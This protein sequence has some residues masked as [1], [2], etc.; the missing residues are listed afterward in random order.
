METAAIVLIGAF[1]LIAVGF[2][3]VAFGTVSAD[4][5]YRMDALEAMK[6]LANQFNGT[7]SQI[8]EVHNGL[9][10]QVQEMQNQVN[11]HEMR[12]VSKP[13]ASVFAGRP[14]PN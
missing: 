1:A 8:Q 3:G 2:A 14:G 9:A 4:R 12:L 7:I 5:R 11:A 13:N 6:E 10:M